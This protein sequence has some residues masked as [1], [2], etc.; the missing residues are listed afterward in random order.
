MGNDGREYA[1]NFTNPGDIP[2]FKYLDN[3]TGTL[4]ELTA[5]F[6]P[7]FEN[8]GIFYVGALEQS[9][10]IP[11]QIHLNAFPNPFNPS[12][13]LNFQVPEESSIK[14][15]VYNINGQLLIK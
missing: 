15:L 8:N 4:I 5:D 9:K 3:K 6:I 11:N 13:N 1:S 14:L 2:S 12:T 10:P 7:N